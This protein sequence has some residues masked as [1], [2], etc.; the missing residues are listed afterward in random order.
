MLKEEKQINWDDLPARLK[1]GIGFWRKSEM[2]AREDSGE[3][4]IVKRHVWIEDFNIPIIKENRDYV[5]NW[6]PEN[7]CNE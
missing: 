4:K 5:D 7:F 3:T 2:V 6:I 1:Y